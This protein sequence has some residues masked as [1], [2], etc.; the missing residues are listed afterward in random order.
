MRS[1]PEYLLCTNKEWDKVRDP[2][3]FVGIGP[4]AFGRVETHKDP[5][6]VQDMFDEYGVEAMVL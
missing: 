6:D 2:A 1:L 3:G 4:Y 5:Q